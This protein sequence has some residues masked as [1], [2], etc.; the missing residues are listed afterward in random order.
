MH[1]NLV[2]EEIT[3]QEYDKLVQLMD[4]LEHPHADDL[5]LYEFGG[6]RDLYDYLTKGMGLS[7]QKGRG[8]AWHRA[9]AL[10]NKHELSHKPAPLQNNTP[11]FTTNEVID[12][13]LAIRLPIADIFS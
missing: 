10:I 5:E 4:G 7:V 12:E 13:S 2:V 3:A 11:F 9:N 6:H 8:P 1:K